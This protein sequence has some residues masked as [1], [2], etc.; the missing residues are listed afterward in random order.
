MAVK[1][2]LYAILLPFTIWALEGLNINKFFKPS[3]IVQ[4]RIIYM[5]VC[6][7]ISYL[8]VNFL[9]DFYISC[10]IIK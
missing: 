6:I 8:V 5:L 9:Y 1:A 7:S 10:Q 4:A 2:I 3:R